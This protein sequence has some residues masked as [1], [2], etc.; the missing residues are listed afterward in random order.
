MSLELVYEVATSDEDEE[1]DDADL[2]DNAGDVDE[3]ASLL[4]RASQDDSIVTSVSRSSSSSGS[5]W[6]NE[7]DIEVINDSF[8]GIRGAIALWGPL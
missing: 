5:V 6:G 4:T 7:D 8:K 1:S 2:G 3:Y